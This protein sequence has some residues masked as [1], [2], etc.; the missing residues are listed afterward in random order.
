MWC[1]RSLST[2]FP[3]REDTGHLWWKKVVWFPSGTWPNTVLQGM[4]S[5]FERKNTENRKKSFRPYWKRNAWM[6]MLE[7]N[8]AIKSGMK[9]RKI[10]WIYEGTLGGRCFRRTGTS[11]W[12]PFMAEVYHARWSSWWWRRKWR[13]SIGCSILT[14]TWMTTLSIFSNKLTCWNTTWHTLFLRNTKHSKLQ[15]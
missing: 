3:C 6:E 7:K 10:T 1:S 14:S 4:T 9:E 5:E 8:V 12:M 15:Y 2:E 11:W 13:F